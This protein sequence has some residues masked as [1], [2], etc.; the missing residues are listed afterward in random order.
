MPKISFPSSG[1]DQIHK[2]LP[3][4]VSIFVCVPFTVPDILVDL[5]ESS[6]P[7]SHRFQ[8]FKNLYS[9]NYYLF[10]SSDAL[11]MYNVFFCESRAGKRALRSAPS[12]N[13]T[14]SQSWHHFRWFLS[15]LIFTG[16]KDMFASPSFGYNPNTW[17]TFCQNNN[18]PVR[19]TSFTP[20]CLDN[21][22]SRDITK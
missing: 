19:L 20:R 18:S 14:Q 5:K 21:L 13:G 10:Y 4:R 15:L 7:T 11:P 8:H 22:S 3:F 17:I 1:S 2:F 12:S 6:V 9:N 16:A